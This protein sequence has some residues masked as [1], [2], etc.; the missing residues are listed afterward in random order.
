MLRSGKTNGKADILTRMPNLV[1][2]NQNNEGFKYQNRALLLPSHFEDDNIDYDPISYTR[3]SLVMRN[4]DLIIS[5]KLNLNLTTKQ[6]P[7]RAECLK[8]EVETL[9]AIW[10]IHQNTKLIL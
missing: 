9:I 7:V 2:F 1:P 5:R 4:Q 3:T 6:L 10:N 8:E